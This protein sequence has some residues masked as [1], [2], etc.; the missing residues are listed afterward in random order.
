MKK[1]VLSA[2][3]CATAIFTAAACGCGGNAKI[4]YQKYNASTVSFKDN[5][6]KEDRKSV[7]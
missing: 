4:Q 6:D 2:V 1:A 7:V 5:S 3:L